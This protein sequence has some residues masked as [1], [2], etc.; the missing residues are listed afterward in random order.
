[1]NYT[2][3]GCEITKKEN[4]RCEIRSN[5]GEGTL[6]NWIRKSETNKEKYGTL[7]VTPK[8]TLF[9]KCNYEQKLCSSHGGTHRYGKDEEEFV[10][11]NKLVKK[12]AKRNHFRH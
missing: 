11:E 8:S 5:G 3:N 6:T 9:C 4:S 12:H 1:M 7:C 10:P 2:L